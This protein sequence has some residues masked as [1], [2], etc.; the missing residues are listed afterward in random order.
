MKKLSIWLPLSSC[1]FNLMN[2]VHVWRVPLNISDKLLKQLF[3]LLSKDETDRAKKFHF[4]KD[5]KRYISTR[6]HLRVLIGKYLD[7]K[8]DTLVFNYNKYGKPFITDN[9]I[10]FNVSHSK[11]LGLI[12]FDLDLEVGVDIEW[13]RPDFGGLKIAKRFFSREELLEL[14]TLPPDEQ[15]QGFFNCWSRK[16]A[17]IKALGKGLAI[18][19][20][21]FSVNLSPGIEAVLLSTKHNPQAVYNYKLFNLEANPG[22]ASALISY[23]SRT[24]IK[25]FDLISGKILD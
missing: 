24:D 17:Y 9:S 18:P 16:E 5:R 13:K 6:G 1:D 20:D 23:K 25:L 19:L 21:K 10:Q 7:Q 22:Y 4:E 11:E 8:P 3:H 15:A 2:E 12:A 14:E